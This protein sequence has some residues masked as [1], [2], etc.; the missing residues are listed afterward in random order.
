MAGYKIRENSLYL[1]KSEN[2]PKTL[3]ESFKSV[4]P[5]YMSLTYSEAC[6]ILKHIVDFVQVSFI[7][8]SRPNRC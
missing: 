1:I 8:E 4:E 3:L 6:M 7:I 2:N 5:M